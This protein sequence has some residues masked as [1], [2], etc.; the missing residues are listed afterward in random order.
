MLLL[1]TRAGE[2]HAFD[3]DAKDVLWSYE[4]D[5]QIFGGPAVW[6]GRA[7]L[8]SWAKELCCLSLRTGDELWKRPLPAAVTA[9]PVIAAGVL[10]L[11]TEAGDLLAFDA[12]SGAPLWNERVSHSPIQASPLPLGDTLVV[13]SL[14]GTVSAYAG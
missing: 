14:D 4:A 5:G 6:D 1:A 12:R 11:V 9:S 2:L 10:Y 8:A 7:Y 3:T 13:A